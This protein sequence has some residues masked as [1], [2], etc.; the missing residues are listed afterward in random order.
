MNVKRKVLCI[1]SLILYLL[2]ACTILSAKIEEEMTTLVRVEKKTS[3]KRTGRSITLES[4][5]IFIDEE[6]NHLY[7][8][9]EGSGWKNGLRIYEVPSF[10]LDAMGGEVSL[11]GVRDYVFIRSASRHPQEGELAEVVE[12]FKTVND[13]YLLYY[14]D[15]IPNVRDFPSNT[16]LIAQSDNAF[17]LDVK[18]ASLPFFPH[19]V[20]TQTVVTDMADRIF[21]L[22]EAEMF[23]NELPK[24]AKA[25]C[26]L[27]F[28]ITLC[29]FSWCLS[30]WAIENKWM[31]RINA[32]L[33]SASLFFFH[34]SLSSIDLP[35]SMLPPVNIFDREYYQEEFMLLFEIISKLNDAEES[36]VVTQNRIVSQCTTSVWTGMLLSL[37]VIMVEIMLILFEKMHTNQN[38]RLSATDN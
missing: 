20:K 9:R 33:I 3:S 29:L 16:E 23:L 26:I 37:S 35:A 4:R 19:L 32:I 38:A 17:L 2:A 36:I 5:S 18:D 25:H 12:E 24:I 27:T 28:G 1:F 30:V 13:Q 21:S 14:H 15:G 11:W 10:G 31:I 7:E 8:V 6:G 22:T 34:S